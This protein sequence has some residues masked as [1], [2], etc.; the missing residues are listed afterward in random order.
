MEHPI[1]NFRIFF[2]A[3]ILK[4]PRRGS[5]SQNFP[6]NITNSYSIGYNLAEKYKFVDLWEG[7]MM[8]RPTLQSTKICIHDGPEIM[9]LGLFFLEFP[10]ILLTLITIPATQLWYQ[11]KAQTSYFPSV[12]ILVMK[13]INKHASIKKTVKKYISF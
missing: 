2:V 7:C 8:G 12:S 4:C 9:F 10:D 3:A 13:F 1:F 5:A 6:V 11:M